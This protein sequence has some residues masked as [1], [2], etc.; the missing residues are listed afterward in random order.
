[1]KL[2][3]K[4]NVHVTDVATNPDS[5][6]EYKKFVSYTASRKFVGKTLVSML[7]NL[8]FFNTLLIIVQL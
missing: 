5:V 3:Y 6:N 7:C 4:N 2:R 8:P 1:M